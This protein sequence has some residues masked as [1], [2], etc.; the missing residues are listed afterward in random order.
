MRS[1]M[2]SLERG[3]L[4][5]GVLAIGIVDDD[6]VRARDDAFEGDKVSA[7]VS[8]EAVLRLLAYWRGM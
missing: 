6:G 7:I 1:V 2:L 5:V 8:V 3:A 4:V